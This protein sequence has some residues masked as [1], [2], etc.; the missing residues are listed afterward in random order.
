MN[1]FLTAALLIPTLTAAPAAAVLFS[2]D[3][4]TRPLAIQTVVSGLAGITSV[5][6]AGDSRLFITE[7]PGR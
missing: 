5:A 3:A 7:Q 6:N 4:P 2:T 1:R